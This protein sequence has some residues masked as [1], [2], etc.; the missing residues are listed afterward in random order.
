MITRFK[1]LILL[2]ILLS[3]LL[4][5][6]AT[7]RPE[8]NLFENQIDSLLVSDLPNSTQAAISIYDLTDNKSLYQR[9]ET[10]LLRPAS[11]QKI[12]TTSAAY[13]FLG[14]D[15]NFET[16]IVHT[17][18]IADSVL[19]GD[20]YFVGGFD[21]DFTSH[22]LDSLVREIKKSG[23]KEINGDVYGDVSAMDSL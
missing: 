19:C 7:F 11:N 16:K 5:S 21:P 3:V 23:I 22:D 20:L 15:Y 1:I 9:N 4:Q 2:L 18:T 12:L 14:N 6:C 17:G 8:P 13:L 10:L